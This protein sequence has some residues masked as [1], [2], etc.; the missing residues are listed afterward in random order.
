[1]KESYLLKNLNDKQREA[2][3]APRINMLILAGAGVGKTRVLVHR[4]AWLIEINKISPF[5]IMAVTFTNKAANE[6]RNRI[7]TLLNNNQNGIL[8]GTFHS[9]AHNLLR[10]YYLEAN[11][12]QNFQILDNYDQYRLLHK[13]I[14][15]SNLD[16]NKWSPRQAMWYINIKKDKG[17][18]PF[19]IKNDNNIIDET[20]LKIYSSYQKICNR[21][22]LVDFSELLLRTYELLLNKPNILKYY[23]ERFTNILVDEFQDTNNI[24]Y[25]WIRLLSGNNSK[26]IIVGDDD[27]S[28]YGWRGAQVENIKNFLQDFSSV[29][30]IVLEQNYRSTNNIIKSANVLI[31]NNNNRL[32]K[33]LW[34]K[35]INGE[36]ISL[37][38]AYNELDEVYYVINKIKQ[39]CNNGGFLKQCAILYRNNAQSNLLEEVLSQNSIAYY[40]YGGKRFFERQE[41]KNVLYYLRLILN[42][43]D[44]TSFERIVNKPTRGIGEQ[45]LNKIYQVAKKRQLTL[46]ESCEYLITKKI[47]STKST[48]SIEQFIKLINKLD[49]ETIDMP[50]YIQ[51]DYVIRY[52]GLLEMYKKE[53]EEKAE[54][55]IK[56][57]KELITLTHNF[58][59]QK[60]DQNI[61]PLQ[62]FL[63]QISLEL[64]AGKEEIQN[65][66]VQLMTLHSAK[67]L[68]FPLVF[69]IGMEE[70]MFPS[71]MSIKEN[72]LLSEERRLA[73][74]GLTR[75]MQK[76]TLTYAKSR[77]LYGKKVYHNPSRFITELPIECIKKIHLDSTI[78]YSNIYKQ[79]DISININNNKYKLGQL[80]YHPKFGKGIIINIKNNDNNYHL[81]IAFNNKETKWFIDSY[82]KLEFQ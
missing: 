30:T 17:L 78:I 11:L 56:N 6:M 63:S 58:N 81:Q 5:S 71:K 36:L 75:A 60:K 8:V 39:W 20:W 74:V 3:T 13:I 24:Q 29:K 65:D 77:K 27:Q 7:N 44:D 82:V 40:I 16:E 79:F 41:I 47:L 22:G 26:V 55:Y 73:Y 28:I 10:S 70:G 14:K 35:D 23:H 25:N 54:V 67:G 62:S 34:T 4:I 68:E 76:L 21:S 43:N 72:N 80:V 32:I 45:T 9:L 31:A 46:W 53:K 48:N 52:S 69:I 1:M 18:R 49:K 12:P 59:Y 57:L 38:C 37:Y 42:R 64:N 61:I 15:S 33:N 66:A 51:T 2:V 19:H 50:L